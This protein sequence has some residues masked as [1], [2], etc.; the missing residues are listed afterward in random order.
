M[1]PLVG[2]PEAAKLL[3]ISRSTLRGHVTAGRIA[4]CRIGESIKFTH[5]DVE[6]FVSACRVEVR[7]PAVKPAKVATPGLQPA[8]YYRALR[9]G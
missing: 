9:N 6:A 8:A 5:A 2:I 1:I 3:D 7:G 4:Y